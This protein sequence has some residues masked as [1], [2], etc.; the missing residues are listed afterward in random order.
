[1]PIRA[2]RSLLENMASQGSCASRCSARSP[3][4]WAGRIVSKKTRAGASLALQTQSG[5]VA[6]DRVGHPH[7]SGWHQAA[8]TPCSSQCVLDRFSRQSAC[9]QVL[10]T[11]VLAGGVASAIGASI[12]DGVFVGA[13][14]GLNFL[15]CHNVRMPQ[16]VAA[17]G[18][19][20]RS[21]GLVLCCSHTTS[22]LLWSSSHRCPC[23][24]RRSS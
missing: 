14:V 11:M 18:R 20:A 1:M 13:L 15:A 22:N 6:S 9:S 5:S 21:C 12:H 7:D 2:E 10:L 19:H 24:A 8:T 3:G 23:Q 4:D 16:C 17:V